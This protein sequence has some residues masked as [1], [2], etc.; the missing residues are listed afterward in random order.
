MHKLYRVKNQIVKSLFLTFHVT[1]LGKNQIAVSIFAAVSWLA[2]SARLPDGLDFVD[3]RR[4]KP[5]QTRC[6]VDWSCEWQCP[7]W[8]EREIQTCRRLSVSPATAEQVCTHHFGKR[9]SC[10]WR[11][12]RYI[13]AGMLVVVQAIVTLRTLGSPCCLSVLI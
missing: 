2:A 1:C 5:E 6:D 8:G 4:V 10:P 9:R 12:R 3:D 7:R 13:F 11:T